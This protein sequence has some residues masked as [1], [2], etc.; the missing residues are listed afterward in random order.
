MNV[1]LLKS[2][3]YSSGTP[4]RHYVLH[5]E[6]DYPLGNLCKSISNGWDREKE[7]D[8]DYPMCKRCLKAY[9]NFSK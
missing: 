5:N 9:E 6:N 7:S 8:I 2:T 4:K 3:K 1:K